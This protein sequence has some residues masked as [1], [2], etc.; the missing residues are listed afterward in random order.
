ML[1]HEITTFPGSRLPHAWLN[2]RVPGKKFS[3]IDLAGHGKFCLLTGI[4]G[5]WWKSE[6]EA[7]GKSPGVEIMCYPIGWTQDYKDV[8]FDWARRREVQEDGGD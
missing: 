5:E 7:V 6:A 3:T 2:T 8:Y 4:G 1:E